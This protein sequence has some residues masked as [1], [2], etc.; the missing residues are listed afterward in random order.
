MQFRVKKKLVL[1]FIVIDA[2]A[3]AQVTQAHY[4][5]HLRVSYNT[6]KYWE[7]MGWSLGLEM[8][9]KIDETYHVASCCYPKYAHEVSEKIV[10]TPYK[11]LQNFATLRR[12][13]LYRFFLFFAVPRTSVRLS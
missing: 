11:R 4:L 13:H 3:T 7:H 5:C 12:W 9:I 2:F 8:E 6:S 10:P 1:L